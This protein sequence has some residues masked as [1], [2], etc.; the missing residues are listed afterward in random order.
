MPLVLQQALFL[1]V[2]PYELYCNPKYTTS[3][4][5]I[6]HYLFNLYYKAIK[7]TMALNRLSDARAVMHGTAMVQ[8]GKNPVIKRMLDDELAEAFGEE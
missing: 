4:N 2:Y 8:D 5:I 6:P 3:D 7:H 1:Q